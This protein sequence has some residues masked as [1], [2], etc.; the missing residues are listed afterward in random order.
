MKVSTL[1]RKLEEASGSMASLADLLDR[2]GQEITFKL[3]SETNSQIEMQ[4]EEAPR[5]SNRL[6]VKLRALSKLRDAYYS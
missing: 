3:L 5:S 2:N 4:W 6:Y 1:L